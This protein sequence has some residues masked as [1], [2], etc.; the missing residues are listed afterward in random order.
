MKKLKNNK[1]R[2]PHGLINDIFKPGIIGEDLKLAMLNLFNCIKAELKIPKMF[3]YANITTIWKKKGSR[4]DLNNDRGIFVVSVMRMMLDSLIYEDK[5]KDI[6]ENMSDSNIGAR[7]NRN[8][9]DHLFI[10]NGI[11]NS[12]LN[13]ES[14]PIDIQIYDVQ[15][16]FDALW[17]EDCMLDIFETLPADARDD[18]I[19]LI[20]EMNKE[21]HVAVK[22][23]VGLTKREMIPRI[24]MQGGK[25][26]PLK[27]SNTM[28]KI[29]KECKNKGKNLYTYKGRVK[30][31]PLA[32]I[33][34]LLGIS[35]C[36]EKSVELNE[37]INSKIEAKK[38][39]FHTPDENGNSKCHKIHVGK[40]KECQE[41]K[42]HGFP[43][44]KV[45][46]DTYLGDIISQD[47]KNKHNIANRVA[48]G[49]GLVG[50]IMDILKTVS[51]GEHY[52]EIATTLRN[53]ILVNGILTNCEVW[54]GLTQNDIKQLED[55]DRLYLRK[56][57]NAPSTCPKEALYLELGCV[58]LGLIIKSRR[59]NYL[60]HL[61]TRIQTSMLSSFFKAQWEYPSKKNEWTEQVKIDLGQLGLSDNLNWIK[62]KSKLAF[63]TLVK[64]QVS[65]VALI[66]L[67]NLKE[68]HSKMANL[69]YT[70]LEMQD[71][72][73]DRN[74]TVEQAKILFKFR[75]RM[76]N[77]SENYRGGKPIK[78]C[79]LCLKNADMQN[80]SFLCNTISENIQISGTYEEIFEPQISKEMA[81]LVENI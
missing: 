36:G 77:F 19:A 71:Y 56:V 16:C 35:E 53:S 66:E 24:V 62:K 64:K 21:N 58:P 8:I 2:D 52:F 22:T 42:V 29:G 31:M 23:A 38:L 70:S 43:V 13:G 10:V 78:L 63:K 54:Y 73:K 68:T 14:G 32:M 4:R 3:Q 5:Y 49:I 37:M 6:D 25:W 26:G 11:I 28:D 20:Y 17:L 81:K 46:N 18:K 40:S 65:E 75:T 1:T 39:R 44:D 15:K 45:S 27:C 59:V 57:L 72:L 30:I 41:L 47:G 7:K 74:I 51:F 55:V 48:K 61:A 12:V 76:A 69:E 60:H 67:L 50:Q 80:H 33:D 9:R 34:D 79:P